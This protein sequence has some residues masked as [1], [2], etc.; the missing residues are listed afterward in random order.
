MDRCKGICSSPGLAK[1]G[2]ALLNGLFLDG[3]M[4]SVHVSLLDNLG[5]MSA[6]KNKQAKLQKHGRTRWWLHMRLIPGHGRQR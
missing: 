2:H 6:A 4:V 1:A 3:R 5:D